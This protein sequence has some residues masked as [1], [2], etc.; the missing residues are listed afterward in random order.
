MKLSMLL[1]PLAL[2]C[3]WTAPAQ[4]SIRVANPAFEDDE[5]F[6]S[7]CFYPA[8]TGWTVGPNSGVQKSTTTDFPGGVPGGS[9][10]YAFVGNANS[11]GSITQVVAAT[12]QANQTYTLTMSV[13]QRGT[14]TGYVAALMANG[15]MLASDSSLRP[16]SNTFLEE[17][18]VYNSGPTP[19]QIGYPLV[20]FVKSYGNGQVDIANVSLTIQ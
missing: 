14:F 3:L 18:I 1:L 6:C 8:I 19:A 15:V 7:G 11:T 17:T 12:V 4:T 10:N 2:G 20:I 13:G 16:A 9:P 5:I